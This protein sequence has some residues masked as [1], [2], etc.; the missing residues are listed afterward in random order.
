MKLEMCGEW[1]SEGGCANFMVRGETVGVGRWGVEGGCADLEVRGEIVGLRE[2][3]DVWG[4]V[5]CQD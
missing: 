5:L 1:R 3:F 4:E 2:P